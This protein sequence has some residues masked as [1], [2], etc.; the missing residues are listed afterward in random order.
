MSIEEQSLRDLLSSPHAGACV[1]S[2]FNS[3][4]QG[5]PVKIALLDGTVLTLASI[6]EA[7]QALLVWFHWSAKKDT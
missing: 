6:P 1:Q 5:V 3:I 2:L 4:Q 7:E